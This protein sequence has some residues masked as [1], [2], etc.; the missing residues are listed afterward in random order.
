MSN[1]E[2]LEVAHQGKL[3]E[4]LRRVEKYGLWRII[5][6]AKVSWWSYHSAIQIVSKTK[7]RWVS[8]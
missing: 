2:S 8:Y 1:V 5:W 3:N 4:E 7:F 6:R